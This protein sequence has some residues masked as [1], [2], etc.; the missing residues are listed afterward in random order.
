MYVLVLRLNN[1]DFYTS[2][3]KDL[4]AS[5]IIGMITSAIVS[6]IF[7]LDNYLDKMSGII[8]NLL[9]NIIILFFT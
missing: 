4:N 3:S 6:I 7:N 9:S 2:T 1:I 5:A 8:A